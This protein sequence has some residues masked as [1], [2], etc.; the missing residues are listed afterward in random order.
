MIQP[1]D[2][3]IEA[4]DNLRFIKPE[5]FREK[6]NMPVTNINIQNDGEKIRV[7]VENIRIAD[8]AG[9]TDQINANINLF[10]DIK[11]KKC[12]FTNCNFHIEVLEDEDNVTINPVIFEKSYFHHCEVDGDLHESNFKNTFFNDC[13]FTQATNFAYSDFEKSIIEN[14]R[15]E[16][17]TFNNANFKHAKLNSSTFEDS[18]LKQSDFTGAELYNVNLIGTEFDLER[19]DDID[20]DDSDDEIEKNKYT[21]FTSA[22]LNKVYLTG[23]ILDNA[24]MIGTTFDEVEMS[25]A[26]LIQ[27]N[28]TG[29]KLVNV[30]LTEADLS[31]A[32]LYSTIFQNVNLTDANLT[33]VIL[34]RSKFN[35]VNFTNTN[36]SVTEKNE[37]GRSFIGVDID[38]K[39]CYFLYNNNEIF[40][41]DINR[42]FMETLI[43]NEVMHPSFTPYFEIIFKTRGKI[44]REAVMLGTVFHKKLNTITNKDLIKEYLDLIVPKRESQTQ[45]NRRRTIRRKIRRDTKRMTKKEDEETKRKQ[46]EIKRKQEETETNTEH[47]RKRRK[48]GGKK[49]KTK[50]TKKTKKSRK[51]I[52][53]RVF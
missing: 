19:D 36:F 7:H 2:N 21:N 15:L 35:N 22:R 33:D 17:T 34:T 1:P 12:V 8:E 52:K 42:S 48:I 32:T 25:S 40:F 9:I 11:A 16:A 14:S 20:D 4:P 38:T 29:A 43:Q 6:M 3:F 44:N 41:I 5:Y 39:T 50:K 31:E 47:D 49:R 53:F 37:V 13:E 23:S 24:Q 26:N 27:T 45:K 10:V 51:L 46:E 28:L 30:N 18:H